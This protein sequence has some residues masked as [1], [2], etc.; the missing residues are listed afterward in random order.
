MADPAGSAAG[1]VDSTEVAR[2]AA[3]AR[4]WWDPQGPMA[5]LHKLNPVRLGYI[6][7]RLA[8]HFGRDAKSLTPFEGLSLLDIGCGGGL[9]S[10]PMA[11][12]GFAVTGIDAAGNNIAVAR[13]HAEE[14][15]LE[16]DYREAAA[17]DLAEAGE[18]YD[19]VL[20]LEVVEHVADPSLFLAAACRLVRPDGA[21]IGATLN[22]TPKSFL[23][24]IV[25]AEYV[26]RW[27]PRGTHRWDRF[28]RPSE[29][30]AALR[31]QGLALQDLTGLSY[32][33]L[34]GQWRLGRD[35][36][37]NYLLHA[38]KFAG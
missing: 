35:L 12:L 14:A 20:A 13:R 34:A 17:E 29:F 38:A 24:G 21:F 18:S 19:V 7:D 33:L 6:R 15:E 2:F 1:S 27:L 8:Q 9:V 28:M 11:R 4:R 30:A 23:L 31:G 32:D 3:L 25:G 10:E 36:E 5:P 22:R 37:V 26:L 16:I